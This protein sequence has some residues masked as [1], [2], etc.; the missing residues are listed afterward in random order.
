MQCQGGIFREDR[1]AYTT[2]GKLGRDTLVL[3]PLSPALI[4]AS[5]PTGLSGLAK[6]FLLYRQIVEE[7]TTKSLSYEADILHAFTGVAEELGPLIQSPLIAGMPEKFFIRAML[8]QPKRTTFTKRLADMKHLD[9]KTKELI[10]LSFPSWSWSGWNGPVEHKNVGSIIA[11]SSRVQLCTTAKTPKQPVEFRYFE[12]SIEPQ[13]H[14]YE[15]DMS[16]LPKPVLEIKPFTVRFMASV[17]AAGSFKLE[18]SVRG[19]NYLSVAGPNSLTCGLI[20]ID[21]PKTAQPQSSKSRPARKDT[22]NPGLILLCDIE[23][24]LIQQPEEP[25]GSHQVKPW[26]P[27][28][29]YD[30]SPWKLCAVL[31]VTWRGGVAERLGIGEMTKEDWRRS[32]ALN[33]LVYLA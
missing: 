19:D 3:K 8:F 6:H 29:Y 14:G 10:N 32:S 13:S 28:L 20:R 9:L 17:D 24:D 33:Q 4:E 16:T 15:L 7:Y 1:V 12:K 23:Q 2:F 26:G 30:G 31:Y 11:H 18:S 5:S 27:K 22:R 21:D 25:D